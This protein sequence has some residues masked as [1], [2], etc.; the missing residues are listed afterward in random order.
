[1]KRMVAYLLTFL[2]AIALSS[3]NVTRN[4]PEDSYLL[5]RVLVQTDSE[6]EREQRITSEDV[7]KYI[8][9]TPNKHFL[10]TNFYVEVY[11]LASSA[12]S[13]RSRY[14]LI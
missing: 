12:A 6:A 10:G 1:M 2:A 13:A 4:L 11:N 5:Q 3:C 7:Y 14:C 8:R 9:Q